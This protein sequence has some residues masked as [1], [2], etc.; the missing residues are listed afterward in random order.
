[1]IL[2]L[3]ILFVLFLIFVF[4]Q[5]M[6][7]LVLSKENFF[8]N[9]VKICSFLGVCLILFNICFNLYVYATLMNSKGIRGPDGIIGIDGKRGKT[10]ICTASCGQQVCNK[11]VLDKVND[12]LKSKNLKTMKNKFMINKIGKM[13]NSE[14]YLGFLNSEDPDKPNEKKLIEYIETTV[15][16]WIDEILKFKLTGTKFLYTPE[17]EP[18]FFDIDNNPFNEI[19]KYDI[20]N[21]G[22]KYKFKPIIRQQCAL[23]DNLP[24]VDSELELLYTNNYS[25]IFSTDSI[26]DKYGPD[27][28]DENPCPFN[29]L[30]DDYTNPRDISN[31]FYD[32]DSKNTKLKLTTK[33]VWKKIENVNYKNEISF[34]NVEPVKI[35][36]K[37]F[38][39]VGTVWRGT[40][41]KE[42][43]DKNTSLG[44]KKETILVCDRGGAN[45]KPPDSF[46]K[47]WSNIDF[48]DD[49]DLIKTNP[50]KII[51]NIFTIWRPLA[52][53]G[54]ISLGDYVTYGTEIPDKNKF[55][56]IKEDL[57]ESFDIAP[58]NVWTESGFKIK[59]KKSPSSDDEDYTLKSVSIFPIGISD[60]EEETKNLGHKKVS[61]IKN[62]GY[63]FFRTSDTSTHKPLEATIKSGRIIK[64]AAY[65]IVKTDDPDVPSTDLGV[66][67][68]GGKLRDS[69]YSVYTDLHYTPQGI[70]TNMNNDNK[71]FIEHEPENNIYFIS[72]PMGNNFGFLN[73]NRI[74]NDEDTWEIVDNTND[75]KNLEEYQWKLVKI[76]KND[77][78]Y[79]I[80]ISPVV[81]PI[82]YLTSDLELDMSSTHKW[83]L[84]PSTG[85]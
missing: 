37:E 10:G 41:K 20:W 69:K 33:P 35:K 30:G 57:V 39:P 66:G 31:C 65:N 15:L 1:M 9:I 63:N 78:S 77:N 44:P 80:N 67:W 3:I 2:N 32:K 47:I 22:E 85:I 36:N 42:R 16:S 11:L 59:L 34:Y 43:N 75:I 51:P 58:T 12:Y 13:C 7:I 49:L 26:P 28:T 21:W 62:G 5:S 27:D 50:E 17:Y 24:S 64:P 46:K 54:Y 70:I 82:K 71:Y 25:H 48:K 23:K 19:E 6:Q 14:K 56:C 52:P 84:D 45:L 83:N 68:L 79:N 29:Q 8:K 61:F 38:F 72:K 18:S 76:E 55:R 74:I 40:S 73:A 81:N 60:K 53:E 4:Y